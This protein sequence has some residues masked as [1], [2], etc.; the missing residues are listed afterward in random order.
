LPVRAK[1]NPDLPLPQVFNRRHL[2]GPDL[3]RIPSGTPNVDKSARLPDMQ[4]VHTPRLIH[5][6]LRGSPGQVFADMKRLTMPHSTAMHPLAKL[7]QGVLQLKLSVSPCGQGAL[8]V[9]VFPHAQ[10]CARTIPNIL[11]RHAF[12][13]WP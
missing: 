6:F 12:L 1:K 10:L 13:V 11:P 3:R 9:S 8:S 5:H 7:L 4:F 2:C